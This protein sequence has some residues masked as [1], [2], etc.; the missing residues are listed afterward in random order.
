M[1]DCRIGLDVGHFFLDGWPGSEV[2]VET[3]NEFEIRSWIEVESANVTSVH[4]SQP[5]V[6]RKSYTYVSFVASVHATMSACSYFRFR[7]KR[8]VVKYS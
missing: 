1:E 4:C 6:V 3:N 8:R 5:W 7:S 2:E